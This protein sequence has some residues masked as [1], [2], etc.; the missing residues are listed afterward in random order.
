MWVLCRLSAAVRISGH[1]I[2][3]NTSD[4]LVLCGIELNLRLIPVKL[5]VVHIVLVELFEHN[6]RCS[7]CLRS[8]LL[9]VPRNDLVFIRS[10]CS[11]LWSCVLVNDSTKHEISHAVF[12]C[13]VD[14]RVAVVIEIDIN[15]LSLA[16]GAC[17]DVFK[18]P[19]AEADRCC[20]G[21]CDNAAEQ[22]LEQ[23]SLFHYFASPFSKNIP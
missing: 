8:Y 17:E 5:G 2:P 16:H 12:V 3:V 23:W 20:E 10:R 4:K 19:V 7:I 22:P 21:C 11:D 6:S 13:I 9:A 1:P 18:H 14:S 15:G